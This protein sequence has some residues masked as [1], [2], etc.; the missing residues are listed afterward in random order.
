MIKLVFTQVLIRRFDSKHNAE[1]YV[2]SFSSG[3]KTA[4]NNDL[5]ICVTTSCPAKPQGHH[6]VATIF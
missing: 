2:R 6:F 1:V 4:C 3:L 5:A